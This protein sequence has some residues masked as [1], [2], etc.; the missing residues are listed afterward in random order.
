MKHTPGPWRIDNESPMK[1]CVNSTVDNNHI[2]MVNWGSLTFDS[3]EEPLANA[4]L[5]AAAPE[6]LES[7]IELE[8]KCNIFSEADYH[9][10]ARAAIAKAK[11]EPHESKRLSGETI[12]LPRV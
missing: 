2:A 9:V 1:Y 7:L 12:E 4:R 8:S 3:E 5:I 6:L 11:G 10:R